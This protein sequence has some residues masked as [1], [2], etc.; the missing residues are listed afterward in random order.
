MSL[1]DCINNEICVPI[2]TI[3]SGQCMPTLI[4]LLFNRYMALDEGK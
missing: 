4:D 3:Y 2:W 1:Y